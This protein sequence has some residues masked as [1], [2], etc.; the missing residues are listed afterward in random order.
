MKPLPHRYD[1]QLKGGPTGY[2]HLECVGRRTL[3]T[4]PPIEFGGPGDA[5]SP[6]HLLLASVESCFL[7]TFRAV[8]RASRLE[9]VDMNV[10]VEGTVD[11]QAGVTRFTEVVLRPRLTFAPGVDRAK[12]AAAIAKAEKACLVSATLA[13]PVRVDAE[14]VEN[15]AAA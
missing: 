11:H 14:V 10:H 5:W 7:F 9:F 1:V 2:A 4:A 13:I 12:V 6:E 8:A 3:A 15:E